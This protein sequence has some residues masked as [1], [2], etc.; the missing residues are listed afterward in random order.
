[1]F[2]QIH[3]IVYNGQGG[4]SWGE[5][6]DFPIWLRRATINFLN[7]SIDARNKADEKAYNNSTSKTGKTSTTTNL[8]WGNPDKSKI[9]PPS[10]VTKASKK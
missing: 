4:Y 6:Y 10:Y 1:V 8:D 7:K 9:K 3:D 5:V 2:Q